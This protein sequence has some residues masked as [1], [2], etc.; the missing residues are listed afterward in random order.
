MNDFGNLFGVQAFV[1]SSFSGGFNPPLLLSCSGHRR[2]APAHFALVF[3]IL[4]KKTYFFF[5]F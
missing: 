4:G 1:L 5:D 2:I 3:L